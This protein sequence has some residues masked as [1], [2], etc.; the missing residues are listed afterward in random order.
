MRED[1]A[2]RR[3]RDR[4]A[5]HDLVGREAELSQEERERAE[6][7]EDPGGERRYLA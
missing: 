4:N 5:Q 1:V 6:R 7:E 3:E 2:D